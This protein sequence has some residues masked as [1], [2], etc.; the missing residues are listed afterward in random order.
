MIT[1]NNRYQLIKQKADGTMVTIPTRAPKTLPP[2]A[3][4]LY[5]RGLEHP[6]QVDL[7]DDEIERAA[8]EDIVK[9]GLGSV[10]ESTYHNKT[11]LSIKRVANMFTIVDNE[12]TDTDTSPRMVAVVSAGT[13]TERTVFA[14][15][16]GADVRFG[17]ENDMPVAQ[18]DVR[19]ATGTDFEHDSAYVARL[20]IL[21][22][23]MNT[24]NGNYTSFNGFLTK[25]LLYPPDV[26]PKDACDDGYVEP[27][28]VCERED[29]HRG[30]G[31]PLM[32]FTPPVSKIKNIPVEIELL[33]ESTLNRETE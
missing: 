28:E 7:N 23:V 13:R 12:E 21:S 25:A 2:D 1:L 8:A 19:H 16:K 14:V 3:L 22:P 15:L 24:I 29:C 32:A 20:T 4:A 18:I 30:V 17:T 10:Y 5:Q 11:T 27:G 33:H 26:D 9:A 31:H 6:Y